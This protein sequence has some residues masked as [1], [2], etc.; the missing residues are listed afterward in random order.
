MRWCSSSCCS[1]QNFPSSKILAANLILIASR[2]DFESRF[3]PPSFVP[4]FS[5]SRDSYFISMR[6]QEA[7]RR[8]IVFITL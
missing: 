4:S 8:L 5:K 6:L 7:F 1:N 2:F 3:T